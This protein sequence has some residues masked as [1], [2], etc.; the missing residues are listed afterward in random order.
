M[1]MRKKNTLLSSTALVV[2]GLLYL[3]FRE[4]SYIGL[5]FVKCDVVSLLRSWLRPLSCDFT[6]FFLP[7]LLW[8]FSLSCGLLAIRGVGWKNVLLSGGIAFGCG[9]CWE[10][11]QYHGIVNGTGD[12]LDVFMYL[13]GCCLYFLLNLKEKKNE[14]V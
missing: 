9:C 14:K 3:L 13:L 5:L 11:L 10:L 6:R 8:G 2:G 1:S 4:N 7:D 12:P